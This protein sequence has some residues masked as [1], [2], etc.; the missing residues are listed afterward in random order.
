MIGVKEMAS[1]FSIT[2]A[3]NSVSI[4]ERRDARV[5]FT[6]TN[7]S[8]RPLIG[9]AV[10]VMDPPNQS[11]AVWLRL[12]PPDGS[13]R[14]FAVNGVQDYSVEVNVPADAPAGDYIFHLDM[15]ATEDPDETY[16]VGPTVKLLVAEPK[17]PFPWWIILVAL[18]IL[19]VIV[20]IVILDAKSIS[21]QE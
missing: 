3:T 1:A 2:T 17:K 5:L 13:E 4:G 14:D 19:A 20:V 16:T 10:L 7:T 8:G 11:Q 12:Q 9:R 15:L 18:G 6:V 21:R